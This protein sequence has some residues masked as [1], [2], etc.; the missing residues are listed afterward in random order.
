MNDRSILSGYKYVEEDLKRSSLLSKPL[1]AQPISK[2]E[3]RQKQT[4]QIRVWHTEP[5]ALSEDQLPSNSQEI[6][7]HFKFAKHTL[8]TPNAPSSI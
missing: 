4:R 2:G 8:K 6:P 7:M 5:K 3:A 1:S